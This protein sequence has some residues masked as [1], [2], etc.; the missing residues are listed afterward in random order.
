MK[1]LITALLTGVNLLQHYEPSRG[2]QPRGTNNT[3]VTSATSDLISPHCES[4]M[5]TDLEGVRQL[6]GPLMQ[7]MMMM[8][9]MMMMTVLQQLIWRVQVQVMGLPVKVTQ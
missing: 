7:M 5:Q 4:C 6:I 9:M 1:Q 3:A 2:A 8:M